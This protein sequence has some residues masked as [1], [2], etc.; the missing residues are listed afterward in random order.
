MAESAGGRYYRATDVG[1]LEQIFA[2]LSRLESAPL[3]VRAVASRR[4][5]RWLPALAALVVFAAHLA[6]GGVFA[7]R[8]FR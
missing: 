6:L 8:P 2:E 1:M 3:T 4:T 5:W 7:V